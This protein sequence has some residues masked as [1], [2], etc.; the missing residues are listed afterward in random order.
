MDEA[1]SNIDEKTDEVIEKVIRSKLKGATI[2]TIAHKLTS[3]L[4]YDEILVFDKG[5][6]VERGS[7]RELFNKK[8]VFYSMAN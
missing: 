8:G 5:R 3:I 6:I 7:S 4:D 2:I 1:T